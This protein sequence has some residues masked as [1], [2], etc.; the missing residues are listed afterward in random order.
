ME[1]GVIS[2]EQE[3]SQTEAH[4]ELQTLGVLPRLDFI[5]VLLLQEPWR[6]FC[7]FPMVPWSVDR[8]DAT[9]IRCPLIL[10]NVWFSPVI[11]VLE[12]FEP[13]QECI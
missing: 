3:A 11:S 4:P 12:L 7:F 13:A 9:S 6:V 10:Y 2:G 1:D 8:E 5:G